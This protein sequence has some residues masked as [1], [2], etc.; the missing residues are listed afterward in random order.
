MP[1]QFAQRQQVILDRSEPPFEAGEV[2]TVA[3]VVPTPLGVNY[4][5]TDGQGRRA[6]VPER[7]LRA[8]PPR[9]PRLTG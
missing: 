1:A 4:R 5:I 8:L 9:G 7:S 6:W 2:V 3:Q